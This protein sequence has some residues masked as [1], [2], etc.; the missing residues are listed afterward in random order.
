MGLSK[1]FLFW[2]KYRVEIIKEFPMFNLVKVKIHDTYVEIIVDKN[3]LSHKVEDA[4]SI[5]LLEV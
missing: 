1:S 4:I 3:S 2:N 5:S